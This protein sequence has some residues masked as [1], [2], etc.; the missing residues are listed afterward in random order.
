MQPSPG[1]GGGFARAGQ[2]VPALAGDFCAVDGTFSP[3]WQLN[4]LCFACCRRWHRD[5]LVV[6][7]LLW[8]RT[9]NIFSTISRTMARLMISDEATFHLLSLVE[10]Y[11]C[12]WDTGSADYSKTNLKTSVWEHIGME[13]MERFPQFG[14]YS[15]GERTFFALFTE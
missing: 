10:Q 12:L 5:R 15:A 13:M 14:P 6:V 7:P 11:P 1:D 4:R 9:P 8:R 2:T 3:A